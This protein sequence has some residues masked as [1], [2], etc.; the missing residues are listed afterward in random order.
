[1]APASTLRTL[2]TIPVT[3]VQD[4]QCHL[5]TDEQM[6]A[7]RHARGGR[8]QALCGHTVTPMPMIDPDGRPC[9]SCAVQVAPP[10]GSVRARRLGRHRRP[11]LLRRL[12]ARRPVPTTPT[13]SGLAA[14]HPTDPRRAAS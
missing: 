14:S 4:G 9:P 11:G 7:G 1:M 10:G 6:A 3:C 12:L 8:Y 13:S 5:V 2:R